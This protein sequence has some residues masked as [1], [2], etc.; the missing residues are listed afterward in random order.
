MP[1]VSSIRNRNRKRK[2][3]TKLHGSCQCEKVR[4]TVDSETPVPF[5]FCFC[6]ICR[7]TGGAAFG[8]NIMGIRSTLRVQGKRHVRGYHARI[9]ER[10]KTEISEATRWFCAECGSHLY[11]T[12][13]R[14]SKGIWPYASA[15]D[16]PL[17]EPKRPLS[18]MTRF[19]ASWVPA[20]MVGHGPTYPR[21]PNVSIANWHQREGW[22]VTVEP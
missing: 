7:K 6:S 4:F 15:I 21:Y 5:M 11:L 10:G 22:P 14:W 9:R 20:W 19:K 17:P 8:C 16:T 13:D 18:I 1:K 12:D 2:R 3:R